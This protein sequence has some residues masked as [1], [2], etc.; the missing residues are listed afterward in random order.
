MEI[1]TDIDRFAQRC[2]EVG[3][4][5]ADAVTEACQRLLDQGRDVI[6][7]T[8]HDL[9]SLNARPLATVSAW[10]RDQP[11]PNHSPD[12]DAIGLG[13]RYLPELRLTPDLDQCGDDV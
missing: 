6:L 8:N 3:Y 11:T 5:P 4:A 2:E 12:T 13:W 9:S 10:D 1:I 7:Y